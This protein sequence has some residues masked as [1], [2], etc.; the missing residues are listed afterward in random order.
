M[1]YAAVRVSVPNQRLDH[2]FHYI[3][4]EEL[5][6]SVTEGMRVYVPFGKGNRRI[7]G[8]VTKITDT[9]EFDTSK[10]K[11]ISDIAEEYSVVSAKKLELAAWMQKKYY[12]TLNACMMCIVP[13]F[14]NEKKFAC[15]SLNE[16]LEN[17]EEIIKKIRSEKQHR[18]LDMLQAGAIYPVSHV[19]TLLDV[20]NAPINALVKKGILKMTYM[21]E[22][23]GNC[24]NHKSDTVLPELTSEQNAALD[25]INERL[26]RKSIKPILLHGV[27]GSG[28]TEVYLRIIQSV[29]DEGKEAIVLVPEI[30]LTPQTVER[31]VRRFG[32]RVAV[33][34]SR[35]S[36]GERYDQW[37]RARRGEVSIM[38]GPRSAIFTPFENLGVVIIDEEHESS[39][40][41][42]GQAPKY[43]AREVAVKLGQLYGSLTVM[44]SATPSVNSYHLAEIG[45][46][47]IVTLK[48]RVN[49]TFPEVNVV[50]M[51]VELLHKN[52]SIFS[53]ALQK[54]ISVNLEKGKQT[55]VFL[56]RRGYSTF[57]SCR[58]CGYVMKCEH[59]NVSYT[60]HKGINKLMC[61]YCGAEK[62][63]PS[64]CPECGSEYI[65]YF[66]TGTEK[67]QQELEKLYPDAR[68]LRM[69]LD[70]TR[71]KN[72]FA[73]ILNSFKNG[74]ADILIG[75]QMI[76]KGL[77]FPNV[78]L[79]GVVAA[80]ISLNISDY[81]SAEKTFQLLTQ[82]SGRAGRADAKG[83]VYIQTYNPDHYSVRYA[84]ENDYE[85]FYKEE[86]GFRRMLN[87]PPYTN[88]FFILMSGEDEEELKRTIN[89]LYDILK[90]YND[91]RNVGTLY[92]PVPAIISKI[93]KKY[94]W[95]IIIKCE[96]EV[97]L[98]SYVLFCVDKLKSNMK[99][100]NVSISLTI[101]PD[102]TF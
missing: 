14:S 97:K 3:I 29:L 35:M 36:D 50:D 84:S 87:Y 32:D 5:E 4:P 80:D 93:N 70:T 66:G 67:I 75:T 2:I 52:L 54:E 41:A 71:R 21:Q 34:H 78:T 39:Y 24:L 19:K 96:D 40:R 20:D 10:L 79:V 25:F 30:S 49:N 68:I 51:R 22:Y 13:K 15:V 12:C 86:I 56:N 72:S 42:D 58:N 31:F 64:T 73:D 77:D 99:T 9:V 83:R 90:F 48:N 102:Y 18:V 17:R 53:R 46:Y 62:N 23:R 85:G 91:K 8:Y 81:N 38:I 27:T 89:Y 88:V 7:E 100:D 101:N 43:D 57:V 45:Q 37:T 60:Y 59:C 11:C 98:K 76:A 61:H 26:Q 16:E 28:K 74:D 69:D 92:E 82:V 95:R 6:N 44:G 47:D 63:V 94:R 55:I 65:R 33:T 1:K